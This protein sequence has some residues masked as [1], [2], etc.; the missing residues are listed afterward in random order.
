MTRGRTAGG[1]SGDGGFRGLVAAGMGD[2]RGTACRDGDRSVL[3]AGGAGVVAGLGAFSLVRYLAS[4]GDVSRSQVAVELPF[5]VLS[6]SLLYA[7]YWLLRSDFTGR[8]VGRVAAWST[9]GFV[10]LVAIAVWLVAGGSLP[11]Q[12]AIEVTA[13]VGAI[14]ASSGLLVGLESERRHERVDRDATDAV[15]AADRAEERFDFLNRLLRHHLLNGLAVIRGQ[16]ELLADSREDPPDAVEIIHHRSDE[17][18]DLVRGLE[19]LSR[20]A[21]DDLERRAID[22]TPLLRTSVEAVRREHPRAEVDADVGE[23]PPVVGS[24]RIGL[25]FEALLRTAIQAADDDRVRVSTA[26]RPDAVEIAIRYDGPAPRRVAPDLDAATTDHEGLRLFLA[27]SLLEYVDGA[28]EPLDAGGL[29]V[30]LEA[31]V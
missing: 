1:R 28:V 8:R 15:R 23:C 12:R 14:G 31:A 5:V 30:R 9:V 7:G 13:D 4:V 29:S 27:E 10:G 11:L 3:R 6:L 2:S 22:P 24:G 26:P 18:V 16:A 25:A 17:I 19:A 20:A 21:T